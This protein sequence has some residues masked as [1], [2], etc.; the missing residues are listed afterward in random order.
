MNLKNVKLIYKGKALKEE[1][2]ELFKKKM[3][4]ELPNDYIKLL[5]NANGFLAEDGIKIYG[6]DE[7]IERN[8]TFEV[9]EYAPGYVAIGDDSGGRVFLMKAQENEKRIISVDSG[10][11]NPNDM[12]EI[13][14]EN[15]EDWL[16]DGCQYNNHKTYQETSTDLCKVYLLGI[17]QEG[18]KGLIKIKKAFGVEITMAEM[19]DGAKN[20]P[21]KIVNNITYAKAKV[22][23]GQLAGLEKVLKIE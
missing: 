17:P 12:P 8:E 6:I 22:I 20:P 4:I 21:Y 19:L 15:L 5:G 11:M 2:L 3:Q 9:I 1:E 7:L 10:Y 18:V 16:M 13:V 14:T 23:L